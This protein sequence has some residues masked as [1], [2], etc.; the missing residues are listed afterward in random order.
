MRDRV[1]VFESASGGT[2]FLDE[3]G[4]M[5][6]PLQLRLLRVLQEREVMRLG[7]AR[8]VPVN[9]RVIAATHCQLGELVRD[10]RFRED[11][12]YRL[13]VFQIEIPPLRQRRSDIPLLIEHA[14]QRLRSSRDER[15][16]VSCSPA[17]IRLLRSCDW[18]GNVRQLLV[19]IESA[20]IRADFGR[21]D[22]QHLPASIRAEL[23]EKSRTPRYRAELCENEE[24]D[25]IIA[26]L[27]H[28]DGVLIRAA[29]LLGMGR[30]TLWR[31]LRAYGLTGEARRGEDAGE[32]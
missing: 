32:A 19:T 11:L 5:S 30:T 4:E 17:V 13:A 27:Q 8:P 12:L 3:I 31:R 26:A 20:A 1:G 24:R 16:Q 28:T 22:V 18:P 10:G 29:E 7:T 6:L 15:S 14:L 23:E 21:I 9:V 25:A 2:I